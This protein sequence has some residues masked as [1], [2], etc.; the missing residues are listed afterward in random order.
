[1]TRSGGFGG[2]TLEWTVQLSDRPDEEQWRKLLDRLP[3]DRSDAEDAEPD[4]FVYRVRCADREA[5]IPE[6]EFT[7]AWRELLDRIRESEDGSGDR[8]QHRN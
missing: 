6:R 4:R 7:G 8:P 2:L 5:T 3:W 1:V